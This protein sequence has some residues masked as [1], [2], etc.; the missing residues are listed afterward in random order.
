[1]ADKTTLVPWEGAM[2]EGVF[3]PID[4]MHESVQSYQLSDG[5]TLNLRCVVSQV[6]RL[7]GKYNQDKDPI[8]VVK[9]QLVVSTVV[10]A[11]LKGR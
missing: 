8:Y 7:K 11:E 9:S 1:M 3:V 4:A 10:P 5:A 6:V 2:V